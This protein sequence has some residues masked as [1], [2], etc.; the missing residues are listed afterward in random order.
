[1]MMTTGPSLDY[2]WPM[3]S[4]FFAF[5]GQKAGSKDDFGGEHDKAQM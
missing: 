1:M 2:Y 4:L 5:G 3:Q